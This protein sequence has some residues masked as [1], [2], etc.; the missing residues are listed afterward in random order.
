LLIQ[1]TNIIVANL[2]YWFTLPCLPQVMTTIGE[3]NLIKVQ[4]TLL[5]C[6]L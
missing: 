5:I 4:V 1:P 6:L 3:C 2:V